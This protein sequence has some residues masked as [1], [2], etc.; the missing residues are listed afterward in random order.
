MRYYQRLAVLYCT[1]YAY[2]YTYTYIPRMS[3][4][5]NSIERMVYMQ[6]TQLWWQQS[7]ES[8]WYK[9]QQLL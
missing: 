9:V 8:V 1:V 5:H 3:C 6:P 7:Q 4:V 2:T